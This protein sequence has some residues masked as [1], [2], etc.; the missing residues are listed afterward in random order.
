MTEQA[1]R[2]ALVTG[3][4]GGVG[5]HVCRLLAREGVDLT[6]AYRRNTSAR[7]FLLSELAEASGRVTAVRADLREPAEV[8]ALVE[9]ACVDGRLDVLIHAGGPVV[10]QRYV[11]TITRAEFARHVEE[12]VV[13]FFGL[14]E[15]AL[16][17]LR[18]AGGALVA[19]TT[20]AG[21]R[22]PVKDALSSA[23]KAGI[24]A[25]VRAVAKEEGRFGIRANAVGP[26]IMA[27][28]MAATL[29]EVGDFDA[30]TQ[31]QVLRTIPLRRF[32]ATR[33]VAEVAAFLAS[34]RARYVTGQVIDVDGGY[35]L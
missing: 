27:D 16:P 4:T 34:D 20:V 31:A 7:D 24:E 19:I 14:V 13:A 10:P 5:S 11:S 18:A 9:A 21:R 8:Q 1:A 35:S 28:G 32:G 3:G 2:T 6:F 25:L 23:P 17:A 15:A 30:E 33:D 12:E 26:G 29:H 22:F